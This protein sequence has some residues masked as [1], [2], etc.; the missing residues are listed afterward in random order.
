MEKEIETIAD[1]IL[2]E[3]DKSK[4]GIVD[5]DEIPEFS[6]YK[7]KLPMHKYGW[8]RKWDNEFA[9]QLLK[10]A[11]KRNICFETGKTMGKKEARGF[12]WAEDDE[13]RRI[14]VIAKR[15]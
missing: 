9:P 1:A 15:C 6:K 3:I 2:R 5:L 14:F 4:S 8:L 10:E 13:I 7:Q 12:A 11:N